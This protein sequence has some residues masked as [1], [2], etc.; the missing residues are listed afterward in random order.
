[1]KICGTWNAIKFCPVSHV[2]LHMNGINIPAQS[3]KCKFHNWKQQSQ[4][5]TTT[6][7]KTFTNKVRADRYIDTYIHIERLMKAWTKQI[8]LS[9]TTFRLRV[10]KQ[11]KVRPVVRV[12]LS[13]PVVYRSRDESTIHL[14]NE[15]VLRWRNSWIN[16]YFRVPVQITFVNIRQARPKLVGR[17]FVHEQ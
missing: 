10:D 11:V 8:D 3:T 12:L 6:L 5:P 7:L 13:A 15:P 16:C 4:P 2:H 1:M 9:S 17:V 14:V